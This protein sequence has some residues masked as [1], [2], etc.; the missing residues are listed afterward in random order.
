V[1]SILRFASI[2]SGSCLDGKN[3][4]AWTAFTA[5]R[6]PGRPGPSIDRDACGS[7]RRFTE[8][9]DAHESTRIDEPV[10]QTLWTRTTYGEPVS[11]TVTGAT[12]Y[13]LQLLELFR[14]Q[15]RH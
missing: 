10:T 7:P 4:V 2:H 13:L 14:G 8:H 12:A 9:T 6:P 5:T 3:S 1:V 11:V 15:T